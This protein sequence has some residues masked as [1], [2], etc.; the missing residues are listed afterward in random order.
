[1]QPSSNKPHAAFPLDSEAETEPPVDFTPDESGSPGMAEL[2]RRLER[3]RQASQGSAE[4]QGLEQ[5][6]EEL[7]HVEATSAWT[8]PVPEQQQRLAPS[9]HELERQR[10]R[11]EELFELAPDGY[12]VTDLGGYIHEA[13]WAAHQLMGVRPGWLVDKPISNCIVLGDRP[14][15]RDQ[16]LQA[17]GA[18]QPV[19]GVVLRLSPAG[20]GPVY[21]S[22]SVGPAH[23]EYG[24]VVAARWILRDITEEKEAREALVHSERRFRL[25]AETSTDMISRH[26]ADG[27]Y[28]YVSPASR[29][30]LGQ[31]PTEM[32]GQSPFDTVSPDEAKVV[33][34]AFERL[35][36][37]ESDCETI[38]MRKRRSDGSYVWAETSVRAL[39]DE[40]GNVTE[41]QS[42][43][44][45]ITERKKAKHALRL[46]QSA[47]EQTDD[48]VVIASASTAPSGPQMLY[49][50]PAFERMTGYQASEVLGRSP[51]IL[52]GPRTDRQVLDR[53]RRAL[54]RGESFRGELIN[55]R[56]NGEPFYL[57]LHIA[58]VRE[59]DGPITHWVAIQRDVTQEREAEAR[60]R[61][62]EAELAH[63]GRLSTMGEMA[64][65][66]AHELNQPLAAISNF[67]QGC[68]HRLERENP[69]PDMNAILDAVQRI[70][71]QADRAGQIIQR[72][73]SFVDKREPTREMVDLNAVVDDVLGLCNPDLKQQAVSL[74]WVPAEDLPRVPADKIQIEQV[75]LNMVRNA[76]EALSENEL[77]DRELEIVTAGNE[78]G[79]ARVTV[80]DNGPG[81]DDQQMEQI[82]N[83]F[84]TTK[85]NGI[86]MGL[87]I[88]QSIVH[89]HDGDLWA[90][91]NGEHGVAFHL[92]L[93]SGAE[94][95]S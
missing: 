72:L 30:L 7:E 76:V 14:A 92:V 93:A 86:G 27:T 94:D 11:Y 60:A 24:R 53:L 35:R 16:I 95:A 59:P 32:V 77:T 17:I 31:D 57:S 90:E 83:P 5:A 82:F 64:S 23:D 70:G 67:V 91:H 48:A 28:V 42:S 25:L 73:R 2:R 79:V 66:L 87:N 49:V 19:F 41:F 88:S 84:Y 10:R 12:L 1:L 34:E 33:R 43:T 6:L 85:G 45:D 4:A 54:E 21:C 65:G 50:N 13:N 78:A 51:R 22:A 55:Y 81:M 39:R 58:P 71:D 8:G 38:S 15:L 20:K 56:K 40:S 18:D 46:I 89:A 47:V 74:Q 26:A 36:T 61:E 29:T 3:L 37:G 69:A 44:R 52:Q 80:R 9:H 75:L 63:V 68:R 62:H